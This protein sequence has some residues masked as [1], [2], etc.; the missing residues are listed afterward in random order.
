MR[1]GIM[2]S[3]VEAEGD[4]DWAGLPEEEKVELTAEGWLCMAEREWA[5]SWVQAE[6]R[7]RADRREKKQGRGGKTNT[8]G[9]GEQGGC[10]ERPKMRLGR[11][12]GPHGASELCP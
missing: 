9:A 10:R 3:T 4:G 6:E 12:A 2:G 5:A 11:P 1:V 8:A 7:V